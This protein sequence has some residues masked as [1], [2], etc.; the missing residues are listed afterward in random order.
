MESQV[1]VEDPSAL[2]PGPEPVE[3]PEAPEAV[4]DHAGW[5]LATKI[6]FRFFFS[7]FALY[8]LTAQEIESLPG[9][10][11]V[12]EKYHGLWRIV[13]PW[14]G[15]H[16]LRLS[17]D[18]PMTPSGSGDKTYDWVLV[19]TYVALALA[20]TLAWTAL[21]RK[22]ASYP[23]MHQWIRLAVRFSLGGAMIMY[24]AAKAIPLQMPAPSLGRLM[25][26]YG[27]SSPMGLLWAFIGASTSYEIFTGV[28][29]LLGGI[30]VLLPRTTLLG[31]LICIADSAM[32]FTLN[33]SYDVPVK[34][35]SL[36]L[37]VMGIFL[38][39]PDLRRLGD[40][41]IRNRPVEPA[42]APRLFKGKWPNRIPPMA[43]AGVGLLMLVLNFYGSWQAISLYGWR[44]PK[45]PLYG[46]WAV[47]ELSIDG[48]QK[49]PLTT[50]DSRWRWIF[51]ESPQY[52]TVQTMAG[53]NVYY[54]ATLNMDEK[55]LALTKGGDAGW[56]AQMT[57]DHPDNDQLV[58]QGDM[59][60]HPTQAKLHRYVD[61]FLLTSR[62]F[63]WVQEVPFNR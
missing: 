57:I 8:I 14:V 37:L 60:G 33:M 38:V 53:V 50:D 62:G 15:K 2:N 26:P 58:I 17:Y 22:R 16:L 5:S 20:A 24:G 44:A 11:F 42:K 51:F 31:A 32:V 34:L 48:Q 36:N 13:I 43:L 7:Y 39:A 49:P 9:I 52:I 4:G 45:S 25:E 1:R 27:Q 21:D 28:A 47:D 55:T 12:M 46:V 61:K 10:S 40:M 29:E 18:M 63:H 6:A 56:K 35:Y 19:L 54:R 30:L 41:F 23:R 3:H 59:D